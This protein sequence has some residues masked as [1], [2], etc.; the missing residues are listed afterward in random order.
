MNQNFDVIFISPLNTGESQRY[1]VENIALGL[2][3]EGYATLMTNHP[4]CIKRFKLKTKILVLFRSVMTEELNNII[5]IARNHGAKIIADFDDLIFDKKIVLDGHVD[6]YNLLNKKDQNSYLKGVVGYQK[7]LK[8]V[9]CATCTTDYLAKYIQNKL[10]VSTYVIPNSL[11]TLQI[12]V[13]KNLPPIEKRSK[14]K[15]PTDEI[16]IAYLS[17]SKTHQ[18][19]FD[20][21]KMALKFILEKFTQVHFVLVGLL[22]L[23]TEWQL[24]QDRIHIYPFM[25]YSETLS[26]MAEKIDINI[27]PLELNNPFCSSK[28]ELKVFEA[29]VVEIPTIASATPSYKNA[30]IHEKTGLLVKNTE[31]WIT[32]LETLILSKQTRIDMGK[33]AKDT[34][35]QHFSY[36]DATRKAIEIYGLSHTT[37]VIAEKKH[38][39]ITFLV[40]NFLMGGGGFRNILRV[41][42]YL[43]KFGHEVSLCFIDRDRS[44]HAIRLLIKEN[45]YPLDCD[46]RFYNDGTPIPPVDILFATHWSTVDPALKMK[47]STKELMYFVQDFEP[48]FFP[49]GT[50][51]ILAENTYSLSYGY[52]N[53]KENGNSVVTYS[54]YRTYND[55]FGNIMREFYSALDTKVISIYYNNIV[56]GWS[57]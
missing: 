2:T 41:A 3:E 25:H 57:R 40:L 18:K 39:K 53:E 43:Q 15:R 8:A 51:Y 6:G 56:D 36:Q 21:C 27:A 12:E 45:F 9:D 33:A 11:N 38:L 14:N 35:L 31:E 29:G 30:I 49:M 52:S 20:E 55:T 47:H 24:F 34:A 48:L 22:D 5:S 7:L 46:I 17:G 28:S 26:L 16:Y 1:R 10:S 44:I 19:D 23:P 50:N 32:A 42:Y 4:R 13:A 54:P 37:S